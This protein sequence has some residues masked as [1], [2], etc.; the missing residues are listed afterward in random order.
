MSDLVVELSDLKTKELDRIMRSL[1]SVTN[2]ESY[3]ADLTGSWTDDQKLAFMVGYRLAGHSNAIYIK[4]GV[5]ALDHAKEVVRE[6][7]DKLNKL[8]KVVDPYAEI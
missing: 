8:V 2:F 4:R 7:E 6:A 1:I 3:F 5:F